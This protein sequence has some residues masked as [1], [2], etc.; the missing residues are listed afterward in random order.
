MLTPKQPTRGHLDGRAA[1]SVAMCT[2]G[3]SWGRVGCRRRA[4][5]LGR[6]RSRN[7]VWDELGGLLFRLPALG[8]AQL[9]TRQL[10]VKGLATVDADLAA[11]VFSAHALIVAIRA[12]AWQKWMPRLAKLALAQRFQPDSR[13]LV[14]LLVR[15]VTLLPRGVTVGVTRS[16]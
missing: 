9:C 10:L 2:R 13:V 15:R 4:P 16:G 6:T 14:T 5:T 11:L 8:T 12:S 3:R 1:N 7:C